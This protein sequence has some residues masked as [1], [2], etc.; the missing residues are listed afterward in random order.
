MYETENIDRERW[1]MKAKCVSFIIVFTLVFGLISIVDMGLESVSNVQG[2]TITVDDSGGANHMTIQAAIDAAQPGN[3]VYVFNGTYNEDVLINK[4]ITLTGENQNTTIINGTGTISVVEITADWTNITDISVTNSGEDF[5]NA[6]VELF[7]ADNCRILNNNIYSNKGD[8]IRLSSSSNNYIINNTIYSNGQVGIYNWDDSIDNTIDNNVISFNSEGIN[9]LS[10]FMEPTNID[11]INNE[12]SN[13]TGEAVY[14]IFST[15]NQ[16]RNNN[17]S[18]NGGGVFSLA[19]SD[20]NEISGNRFEQNGVAIWID[21]TFS[22]NVMDNVITNNDDAIFLTQANSNVISSNIIT[23]NNGYGFNLWM[24][25]VNDITDNMI[26]YNNYGF[27]LSDSPYNNIYHNTII[28]NNIQAQDNSADNLWNDTYPSGG[29]FWSDYTGSDL[30]QG[31]NQDIPGS[32][33]IGDVPYV[34]DSDSKDYYPLM[35]SFGNLTFLGPGW[36]LISC[37]NIQSS[38]VVEEV[39]SQ[40]NGSY[41]AVQWYNSSDVQDPWKQYTVFKPHHLNDLDSIDHT[42]GF[43][44]FITNPNGAIFEFMGTPPTENQNIS[45]KK[46]WNLVGYPSLSNKYRANALNNLTFGPHVDAIWTYNA[47]TQN[48]EEVGDMNYFVRGNGYWIHAIQDCVWE[49]PL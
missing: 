2:T 28:G 19:N 8:G 29:N 6:G 22:N 4:T 21:Q 31:L 18:E 17:I 40:L 37:P 13:N 34:I 1:T 24:S 47:G 30:Y 11:I 46:G 38:N 14:L 41:S 5:N 23:S 43:W 9:I 45:L 36:N 16:I 35:E 27:E 42:M 39:L 33:G 12:I 15:H 44:I 20:D 32:D 26:L 48:W 25:G 10:L 3:T 49:V 7:G